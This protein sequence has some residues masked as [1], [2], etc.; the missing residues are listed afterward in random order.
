MNTNEL[1]KNKKVGLGF[2]SF[3]G[4]DMLYKFFLANIIQNQ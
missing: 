4:L 3:I 2:A 1:F